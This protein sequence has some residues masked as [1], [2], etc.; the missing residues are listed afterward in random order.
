VHTGTPTDS[1]A[2]H[3]RVLAAVRSGYPGH[4]EEVM[5]DHVLETAP[6]VIKDLEAAG[7]AT[8]NLLS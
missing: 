2:E 1:R 6:Q 4:A 5:R 3:V 8:L 7:Q